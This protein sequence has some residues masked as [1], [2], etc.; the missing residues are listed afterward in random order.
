LSL[1]FQIWI[2]FLIH[3]Q[4][5]YVLRALISCITSALY[6]AHYD[7]IPRE[8][9]RL[10]LFSSFSSPILVLNLSISSSS[11][12]SMCSVHLF[13]YLFKYVVLFSTSVFMFID[14]FTYNLHEYVVYLS[15]IYILILI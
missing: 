12:F 2:D 6:K 10:E 11:S 1:V 15:F 9:M 14:C 13:N 8:T 3:V 4:F 5:N 7:E